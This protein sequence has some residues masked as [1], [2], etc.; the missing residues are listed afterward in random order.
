MTREPLCGASM[1][2]QAVP[3]LQ[4]RVHH[5]LEPL[6]TVWTDLVRQCDCYVFQTWEWN[7]TWQRCVGGQQGV[8]P[9]IV[10]I[11]D[12]E[13]ATLALWPLC[14]YRRGRLRILGFAGDLVSDY[15]APILS[16]AWFLRVETGDFPRLWAECLD[17]IDGVDVVSLERMP[18]CYARQANPMAG[19]PGAVH[20]ENAYFAALPLTSEE[21]LRGR[22]AQILAGNRRKARRLKEQGEFVFTPRHT[23]A[24]WRDAF[25]ALVR[26]KS[27]RW[28]ETGSRDLFAESGYLDFYESLSL[29][30][31]GHGFVTLCSIRVAGACV[32]A[33]WGLVHRGRY[34][35]IL[36]SY[37][38]GG[39]EKYSCG[40]IL[41]Q[42][43]I[44]WAISQKLQCFDLTVGDEEYKKTWST[45]R[46]RLYRW[47]SAR[48]LRGKTYLAYSRFREWVRSVPLLRCCVSRAKRMFVCDLSQPGAEPRV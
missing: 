19:L 32:A 2:S 26:Q 14:I 13:G 29:Q 20:V 17:L 3:G 11:L 6:Q 38:S 47:R 48:T 24:D 21:Y 30:Q 42:S 44:E 18:E 5:A 22:S 8:Q 27:H 40:R 45:E 36:P 39:W 4:L 41:L 16:A 34:Y 31:L 46:L 37:A 1:D 15:R 12:S 10:Q 9:R 28:R 43:M 23:Q 33:H 7:A 35:W 25:S